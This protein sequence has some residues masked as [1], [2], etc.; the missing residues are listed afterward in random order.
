MIASEADVGHRVLD[1]R[2]LGE[3]RDRGYPVL[4][5]EDDVA[6]PY[7]S[8]REREDQGADQDEHDRPVCSRPGLALGRD[9]SSELLVLSPQTFHFGL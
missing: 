3:R 6:Q 2:V 4:G 5:V 1:V 8:R 7:G 9:A